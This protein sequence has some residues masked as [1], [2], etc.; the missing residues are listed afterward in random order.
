MIGE[1]V[2]PTYA[3]VS[4]ALRSAYLSDV[5]GVWGHT[6]EPADFG[7]RQK[8]TDEPVTF[9]KVTTEHVFEY[10]D[11]S[12]SDQWADDLR[13]YEWHAQAVWTMKLARRVL[14]RRLMAVVDARYLVALDPDLDPN[15]ERRRREPQYWEDKRLWLEQISRKRAACHLIAELVVK[16]K[17]CGNPNRSYT[18]DV[19]L[20][21]AGLRELVD[22]EQAAQLGKNVRTLRRWRK[23]RSLPGVE[24]LL[25][26][27]LDEAHETLR[28]PMEEIGLVV[29]S[30]E[31]ICYTVHNHSQ[32]SA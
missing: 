1:P 11:G 26:E 29:R 10:L 18:L 19:V 2:F 16:A 8:D 30:D 7:A 24:S 17:T 6:P 25:R 3:D 12:P 31:R 4:A 23:G 22:K 15:A 9:D 13:Q 5:F 20:A 32:A 28:G 14:P 21:F 27:W